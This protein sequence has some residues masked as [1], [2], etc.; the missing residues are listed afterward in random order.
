MFN[1]MGYT[2]YTSV[3]CIYGSSKKPEKNYNIIDFTHQAMTVPAAMVLTAMS[4]CMA[5]T[6]AAYEH[7]HVVAFEMPLHPALAPTMWTLINSVPALNLGRCNLEPDGQ[8]GPPGAVK[9]KNS[10][11][12]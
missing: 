10:L 9:V 1:Y 3:I 4:L 11:K 7:L 12:I 5:N 6:E 2:K 8:P